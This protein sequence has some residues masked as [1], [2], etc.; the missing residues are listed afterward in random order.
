MRKKSSYFSEKVGKKH[1]KSNSQD[2]MNKVFFT[3][4][5]KITQMNKTIRVNVLRKNGSTLCEFFEEGTPLS[6]VKNKI[7]RN[8]N[9]K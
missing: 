3:K 1:F 6:L 5:S 2:D 4:T 9:L 8:L 7:I